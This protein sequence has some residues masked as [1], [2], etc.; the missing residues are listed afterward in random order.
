MTDFEIAVDIPQWIADMGADPKK[1]GVIT[2]VSTNDGSSIDVDKYYDDGVMKFQ[3]KEDTVF[4]LGN[5]SVNYCIN[6]QASAVWDKYNCSDDRA[7]ASE[8]DTLYDKTFGLKEILR[9]FELATQQP[10]T[11]FK[12]SFDFQVNQ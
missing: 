6:Y 3:T 4:N 2:I 12:T 5:Y 11:L 10:D 9:G 7:I 8:S 1:N